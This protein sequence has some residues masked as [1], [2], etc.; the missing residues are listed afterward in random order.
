MK[1]GEVVEEIYIRR[2]G[3]LLDII[4]VDYLFFMFL[5]HVEFFIYHVFIPCFVQE[6]QDGAWGSCCCWF[7][8]GGGE[9]PHKVVRQRESNWLNVI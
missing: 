7:F 3:L 4:T 8:F 5:F 6:V 2:E 1:R 9:G